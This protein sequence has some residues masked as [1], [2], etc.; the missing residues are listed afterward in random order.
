[1]MCVCRR[2]FPQHHRSRRRHPGRVVIPLAQAIAAS[3][4][5]KRSNKKPALKGRVFN[6]FIAMM[7]KPDAAIH[8]F[9][10]RRPA[11]DGVVAIA[12]RNDA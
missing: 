7:V 6:C 11:M 5:D 12:R 2:R 4:G 3:D 10:M 1:M 8:P 9:A